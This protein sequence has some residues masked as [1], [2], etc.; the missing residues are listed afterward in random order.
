MKVIKKIITLLQSGIPFIFGYDN[1]IIKI[2]SNHYQ[3]IESEIVT[4]LSLDEMKHY[5]NTNVELFTDTF[6]STAYKAVN[7]KSNDSSLPISNKEIETMYLNNYNPEKSLF[8]IGKTI[9]DS[10]VLSILK[11]LYLSIQSILSDS[12][13]AL[14]SLLS[15]T[16]SSSITLNDSIYYPLTTY[17]AILSLNNTN[18]VAYLLHRYINQLILCD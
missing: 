4:I 14:L 2:A 15:H 9:S 1:S 12:R 6:D 16:L 18:T 13:E 10:P 8:E 17:N 11:A 3:L 7:Y 5:I